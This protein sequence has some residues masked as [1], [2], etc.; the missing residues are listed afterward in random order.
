M[1]Q[2]QDRK[3]PPNTGFQSLFWTGKWQQW[4]HGSEHSCYFP[5]LRSFTGRERRQRLIHM[6]Q[7]FPQRYLWDKLREGNERTGLFLGGRL[8]LEGEQSGERRVSTGGLEKTVSLQ[9]RVGNGD[10]AWVLQQMRATHLGGRQSG[11]DWMQKM[12]LTYCGGWG[13]W[14]TDSLAV[15]WET[16]ELHSK[17]SSGLEDRNSKQTSADCDTC[18]SLRGTGRCSQGSQE[19]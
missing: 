10:E 12:A 2:E 19:I 4:E 1:A 5:G 15:E 14:W 17:G 8:S 3:N 13:W 7:I 11:G 16:S 18:S 9:E 6:V